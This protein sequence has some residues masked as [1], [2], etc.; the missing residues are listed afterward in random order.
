MIPLAVTVT[1][2]HLAVTVTVTHLAVTVTVTHV[3]ITVAV[4]V[5]VT[6]TVMV[7]V[8]VQFLTCP[9]EEYARLGWKLDSLVCHGPIGVHWQ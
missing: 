8:T 4:T 3:V 9:S 5:T 2:T 6:V 7:T 1:V